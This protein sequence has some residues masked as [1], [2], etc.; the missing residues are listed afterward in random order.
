M[1]MNLKNA[2]IVS[3]LSAVLFSCGNN[4]K[5]DS[6]ILGDI[7]SGSE[8]YT[9]VKAVAIKDGKIIYCG[10]EEGV[11]SLIGKSTKVETLSEGQVVIPGLIDGH[12]HP[13]VALDNEMSMCMFKLED[14]LE[15]YKS[16][17]KAYIAKYPDKELYLGKGWTP[18]VFKKGKDGCFADNFPVAEIL[19]EI[20][21]TKPVIIRDLGGHS[22]WCNTKAI[23]MANLAESDY[24]DFDT[25][26]KYPAGTPK[27][28]KPSGCFGEKQMNLILA[29]VKPYTKDDYIPILENALERFS[30]LG[31]TSY[32]ES[33]INENNNL[34]AY[35]KAEAYEELDKAGKLN[36]YVAG[37]FITSNR[38]DYLDLV[39][40]A[41]ELKE[42]TKGGNFEVTDIKIFMDGVIEGHTA[43]LLDDYSDDPGNNGIGGTMWKTQ[44]DL[45]KLTEVVVKANQ[46]GMPCHFHAIG[47]RGS[48][49]ALKCIEAA[50]AKI[51]DEKVKAARNVITHLQ[52]VDDKAYEIFKKYDVIANINPWCCKDPQF[53]NG[54]ELVYLGEKR[55]NNEYPVKS[56][57]DKGIHTAFGTDYGSSFI[58]EFNECFHIF[59]TRKNASEKE[60]TLLN[61]AERITPSQ[62]LSMMT[63]GGAYQMKKENEFGSIEPGKYANLIVLNQDILKVD[64]PK[65][66][67]TKVERTMFKGKWVH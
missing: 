53:F 14:N 27:A 24:K 26:Q 63:I 3:A 16:K 7:Y 58:F 50:A 21:N 1:K 18:G 64:A 15:D 10:D 65:L 12:S 49:N 56:F 29:L 60:E 23:E 28:G 2:L 48:I 11:K 19:D 30:S 35:P 9:L 42:K 25:I 47:D 46:A 39:D 32:N 38:P 6:V 17:M 34:P 20:C 62:T 8:N 33:M 22:I 43:Y 31:Y 54:T 66:V 41:I 44:E 59:V 61:A 5:A 52:V 57:F 37:S 13:A 45:D 36:M 67:D 51:G 40:E 55:A 4:S